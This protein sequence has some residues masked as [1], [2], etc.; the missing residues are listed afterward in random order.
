MTAPKPA[1]RRP[2]FVERLLEEALFT[3][4]WLLAPF[5]L[6]LAASLIVL[7]YK[8][9]Q[10]FFDLALHLPSSSGN[11]III[12]VLSLID[13]SLVGNLL[14]MVIFAGYENFVSRFTLDDHWDKP[15]WMGHVGFGE[16]KLKLMTSIVAISAI[17]VLEGF[18][19]IEHL[20]DRDLAWSVG[21][22][23][24]F[25][26]SAVLLAVMDRLTAAKK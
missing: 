11:E 20:A 17:Q 22:H 18:M 9:G 10:K 25:V 2:P 21:I 8:F 3:S 1:K 6:G 5:Y 24:M 7:L 16:L 15:D 13:L 23:M 26:V 19:N 12:A 14:L 4:R